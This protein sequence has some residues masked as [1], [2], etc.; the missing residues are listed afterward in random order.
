MLGKTDVAVIGGGASGI[1]AA[2]F[3]ARGGADVYICERLPRVGKKILAA[4]NGRCNLSNAHLSPERYRGDIG[5]VSHAL[6]LFGLSEMFDFF[7]SVGLPCTEL[8]NGKLFPQS[9]QASSVLDLLRA[10][11]ER[12]KIKEIT[13]FFVTSIKKENGGFRIVSED[14]EIF[15]K[16]VIVA[17]GGMAS[18]KFGTDGNGYNLL[19]KFGHTVSELHPAL[20]QIKTEKPRKALKGIKHVGKA[21]LICGGRKIKS[22]EGELLFTDYGLS[23]PPVFNLSGDAALALSRGEKAEISLDLLPQADFRGLLE[24][25]EKRVLKF[26]HLSEENFLNGVLPKKLGYEIRRSE[27]TARGM[28]RLMKDFRFT[29][30]GTTGFANAQVTSGGVNTG[31]IDN[32]TMMSKKVKNLYITGEIMDVDGD[33]GGFNLQWAW[34][35]GALAGQDAARTLK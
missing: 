35:T 22:S 28:T 19:K 24:Q 33:C 32:G 18:P 13:D 12:L 11:C 3:A 21:T 5:F 31:E 4:G 10:E 30:S 23:G 2:I 20:L 27:S 17:C 26:S 7:E 9:L 15:A 29:V 25:M 34:C 6:N 16:K 14:D 8:E 1:A